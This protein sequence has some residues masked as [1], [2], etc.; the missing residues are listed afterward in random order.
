MDQAQLQ[1]KIA[2]YFLKLPQ[3]AQELFSSMQWLEKLKEIST[4]YDLSEEQI[5]TIG[6]ETTLVLLGIIHAEEYV[7]IIKKEINIGE[8]N[9][10]KLLSEINDAIF[11]DIGP[12]LE[13]TFYKNNGIK[14]E[15]P[16]KLDERFDNLSKETKDAI[17]ASDY[18]TKIYEIGQKN[19]LTIYQIGLLGEAT[20][21]VMLGITLPNKFEESL[22]NIGLPK[23]KTLELANDIN[24]QILRKIRE[25]LVK[26]INKSNSNFEKNKSLESR[27]E[28]LSKIE[29]PEPVK[30]I[31]NPNIHPILSQ[32]LT[33][34]FQIPKAETDHTLSNL[35]KNTE[36]EKNKLPKVDPYRMPIE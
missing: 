35:S 13:E 36:E 31:L 24:E 11:K 5:Q 3:E 17:K 33:G 4:K 25:E 18:Q 21:N 23:E 10:D 19:G 28:L 20:L 9:L 22:I 34:P 7:D 6:T 32:K 2:E 8:K 27:E 16:N 26:N 29:N 12:Q 30:P 14:T 15:I 1:Q